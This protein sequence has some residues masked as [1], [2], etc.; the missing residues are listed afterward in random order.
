MPYR[1]AT[2]NL[3][4]AFEAGSCFELFAAEGDFELIILSYSPEFKISHKPVW[5]NLA[6]FGGGGSGGRELVLIM[7]CWLVWNFLCRQTLSQLAASP[8]AGLAGIYYTGV[9]EHF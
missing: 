8:S 3:P 5:I 6:L 4:L 2:I 7:W 1:I 9:S